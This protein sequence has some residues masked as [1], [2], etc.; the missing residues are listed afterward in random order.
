VVVVAPPIV[1]LLLVR[2]CLPVAR[3]IFCGPSFLLHVYKSRFGVVSHHLS[4][5]VSK[6]RG[7]SLPV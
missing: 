1:S 4:V 2:S 5:P 6:I 7:Y 3:I